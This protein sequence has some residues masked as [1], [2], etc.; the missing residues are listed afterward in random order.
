[1]AY[2]IVGLGN[3]GDKYRGTRHNIGSQVVLKMSEKLSEKGT[4][5]GSFAVRDNYRYMR[6][7]LNEQDLIL[8]IPQLYMNCSGEVVA[9]AKSFYKIADEQTIVISDDVNLEPGTARLRFGGSDGGHNGLKSVISVIGEE[10][11]RL[12]IGVGLNDRVPLEDYVLQKPS[13]E[14]AD[15]VGKCIDEQAENMLELISKNQLENKSTKIN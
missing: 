15:I 11:W 10:F 9:K 7:K 8:M 1:M 14:E 13:S 2:L 12:R 4:D 5:I 3:P 6:T